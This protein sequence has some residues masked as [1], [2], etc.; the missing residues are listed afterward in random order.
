MRVETQEPVDR[1][2]SWVT[3]SARLVKSGGSANVISLDGIRKAAG[4]RWPKLRDIAAAR[5][6]QLLSERLGPADCFL[7][8][9]DM[10]RL[11]IMPQLPPADGEVSCL[12][13]AYDLVKGLLGACRLDQLTVAPAAAIGDSIIE[14]EEFGTEELLN[15]TEKAGLSLAMPDARADGLRDTL[16]ASAGEIDVLYYPVWDAE[17]QVIRSYRCRPAAGWQSHGP[18]GSPERLLSMVRVTL[19]LMQRSAHDLQRCIARGE[20]FILTVPVSYQILAAPVP[21]MQFLAG[22][23]ALGPSLRPYL[24]YALKDMP[25]GIPQSRVAE[26]TTILQVFCGAVV[27]RV[28]HPAAVSLPAFRT[29]GIKA[30]GVS[31]RGVAPVSCETEIAALVSETKRSGLVAFADFVDSPAALR[32]CLDRGVRW[33]CG[34]A[35]AAAVGEPGPLKSLPRMKLLKD[36]KAA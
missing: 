20:R 5:L 4:E 23:R 24:A 6:E 13:I 36:A 30:L 28:P 18:E 19:D 33:L 10:N 32:C 22:C 2:A 21:R 27:A 26:V 15:L 3:S 17:M 16:P 29:T 1:S 31:L 14:V 34:T 35:V 11:V 25:T 12:R 7:A 8:L 9:D